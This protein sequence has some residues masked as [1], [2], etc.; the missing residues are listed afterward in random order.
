MAIEFQ[1]VRGKVVPLWA[2]A[3]LDEAP[4]RRPFTLIGAAS[5]NDSALWAG[6]S[7][8]VAAVPPAPSNP[9]R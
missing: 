2:G 4:G 7:T 8:G 6:I 3:F 1:G 9:R 5:V